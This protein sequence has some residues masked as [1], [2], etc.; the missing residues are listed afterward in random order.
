M[1]E[2]YRSLRIQMSRIREGRRSEQKIVM[3]ID[4]KGRRGNR[5]LMR[6]Y[7][8]RTPLSVEY[9]N[10]RTVLDVGSRKCRSEFNCLQCRCIIVNSLLVSVNA[11]LG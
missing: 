9:Q 8:M 11:A 3:K 1:R 6:W 2:V 7:I 10:H 4:I 5:W